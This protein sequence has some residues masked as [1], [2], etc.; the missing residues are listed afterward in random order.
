MHFQSVIVVVVIFVIGF[1]LVV[2]RNEG[3]RHFVCIIVPQ[4]ASIS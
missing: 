1:V 4:D 2:V 3:W